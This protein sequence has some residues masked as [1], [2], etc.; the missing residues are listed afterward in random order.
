LLTRVDSDRPRNRLNDACVDALGRLWFG[1]MDDDETNPTGALY[2]FDAK[3]LRRCDDGYVITNGPALSADGRTLYHVDTLG[4]IIYAFDLDDRGTPTNRRL[5]ARIEQAGAYPDGP[6]IDSEGCLWI[7]VWGGSGV[8]RYSPEGKL[9]QTISLPVANCTKPL[10]AG[11]D[12]RSLYMTTAWKGLS[13]AQREQQPLA[14]GLFHVRV[15]VAG[16]PQHEVRY[17]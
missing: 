1:T 6:V 7:G 14:G 2:R 9:L 8:R 11:D 16:L 5:F 13:P 10:F 12:L 3:G 17:D 4:Q 15:P